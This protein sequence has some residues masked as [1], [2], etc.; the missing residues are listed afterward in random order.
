V[1]AVT[2]LSI[3]SVTT[4]P[5][6]TVVSFVMRRSSIEVSNSS[7]FV[8]SSSKVMRLLNRGPARP[9]PAVNMAT[10]IPLSGTPI[11]G[12]SISSRFPESSLGSSSSLSRSLSAIIST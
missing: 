11:I 7:S 3:S 4:S 1:A 9:N 6:M 8:C 2:V 5:V 10:N 12:S